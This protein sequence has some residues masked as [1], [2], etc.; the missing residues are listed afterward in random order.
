MREL[1][2][3]RVHL[4]CVCCLST[5]PDL[6]G[7]TGSGPSL[8]IVAISSLLFTSAEK[9][10]PLTMF[11]EWLPRGGV[12]PF[13]SYLAPFLEVNS[14]QTYYVNEARHLLW[15]PSFK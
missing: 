13:F 5:L 4:E 8:D 9:C 10:F 6:L 15:E 14:K 11:K 2:K 1:S 3:G 12:W 7:H